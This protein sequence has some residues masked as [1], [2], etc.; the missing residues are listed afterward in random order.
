MD[1]SLPGSTL[2]G[3]LQARV[4]EWVAISFS[5]GSSR[6]R[7]RTWVSHIPGRRF[8]L[9][10]TREALPWLYMPWLYMSS[11]IIILILQFCSFSV[12]LIILSLLHFNM[13]FKV[14][15]SVS[16]LKKGYWNFYTDCIEYIDQFGENYHLNNYQD[17][18]IWYIYPLFIIFKY[19]NISLFACARSLSCGTGNLQSSLQHGGSSDPSQAPCTGCVDHQGNSSII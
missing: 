10:A 19:L 15:L 3:I 5:R 8:N 7:D 18:R 2:H 11:N 13:N 1:C 9:W 14:N 12:I 16:T 4:L 17:L 6:P